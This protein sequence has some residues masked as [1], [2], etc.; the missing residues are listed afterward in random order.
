[1]ADFPGPLYR[2]CTDP[3]CPD[4]YAYRAPFPDAAHF[5]WVGPTER[6]PRVFDDASDELDARRRILLSIDDD[7]DRAAVLAVFNR[8]DWRRHQ[9]VMGDD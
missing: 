7:N 4:A 3:D 8:I 1:M 5:H 9:E 6:M 2:R